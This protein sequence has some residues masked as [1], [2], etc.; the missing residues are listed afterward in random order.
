MTLT[1]STVANVFVKLRR[2]K[3]R[4][5]AHHIDSASGAPQTHPS[6]CGENATCKR[7]VPMVHGDVFVCTGAVD[8]AKLL[9]GSRAS[10]LEKAELLG[11]NVLVD[12]RWICTICGPKNR[13]DGTF[14]V[15][16]RYY[17][18]ASRSPTPD[19]QKPIALDR[20]QNVPGL[21][22]II[23]REEFSP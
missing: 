8:V 18:S 4:T 16:I 13:K 22:T 20:V 1:V 9:R 23:D 14:R 21:M 5:K 10:L 2:A 3:E 15:Q 6:L 11:G 12:E 7:K 17:A 19:P